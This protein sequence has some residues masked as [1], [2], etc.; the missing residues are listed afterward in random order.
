MKIALFGAGKMGSGMA[1]RWLANGDTVQVWNRTHQKAR[2]L[3]AQGAQAFEDPAAAAKNVDIV[4]IILSDD[5][6]VDDLLDRILE[7]L[8]KGMLVIDHT[9]VSPHGTVARAKRCDRAGV[10]FLH[11]PVFMSPQAC[12]DGAGLML[13]SG[14]K[15]RVERA[16][17]HLKAMTGEVWNVGEAAN[18]AA[19]FKLFGNAMIATIV[20][21]LADVYTMAKT[22]DISASD[23][24]ELF[25]HFKVTATLDIRGKKMAA[26]D[27]SPSFELTMARKDVGLMLDMAKRGDSELTILPAIFARMNELIDQ[28]YG[29]KDLGVLAVDAVSEPATR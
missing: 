29:D 17:D 24:R 19:A 5:A 13:V 25:A 16:H 8:P 3:E 21:G 9:T 1:Q 10:E 18:R 22:V 28:G 11:A 2:A 6:S 15:D 27:F 26:G 7:R 12:R 4:H 23:A 20:G 14:P